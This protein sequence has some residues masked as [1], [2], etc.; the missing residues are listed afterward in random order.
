VTAVCGAIKYANPHWTPAQ[1]KEA[2]IVSALRA[3]AYQGI[4]VSG[5]RVNAVQPIA[6]SFVEDPVMD[7]DND[8]IPNLIE[9]LAGTLATSPESTPVV[10]H[11]IVGGVFQ[12]SIPSVPRP[13]AALQVEVSTDLINWRTSGVQDLSV[14][15]MLI[16]GAPLL[17]STNTFLRIKAVP[18]PP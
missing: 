18:T 8:Q 10:S 5:G 6:R 12:I 16:G 4:C 1:I 9:Y 11:E 13:E 3:T 17:P 15:G 7:S 14:P 2:V